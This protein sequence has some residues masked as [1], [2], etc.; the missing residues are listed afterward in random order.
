MALSR[1]ARMLTWHPLSLRARSAVNTILILLLGALPAAAAS[2]P[3]YA[4]A[5]AAKEMEPVAAVP[6][7]V[8]AAATE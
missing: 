6:K 2:S 4:A 1:R 3:A 5:P 7:D 8:E